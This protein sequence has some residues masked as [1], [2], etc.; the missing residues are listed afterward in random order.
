MHAHQSAS[1]VRERGKKTA[2]KFPPQSSV[3]R[4]AMNEGKKSFQ[5][6]GLAANRV[7]AG[8]R[9]R[10]TLIDQFTLVTRWITKRSMRTKA[11]QVTNIH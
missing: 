7:N 2:D 6:P 11:I 1:L 9:E 5:W 8:K 3:Q 4:D 10:K